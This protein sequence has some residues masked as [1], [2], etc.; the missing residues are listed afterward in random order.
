MKCSE[1]QAPEC[2]GSGWADDQGADGDGGLLTV[3]TT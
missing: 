1:C 3:D 2:G